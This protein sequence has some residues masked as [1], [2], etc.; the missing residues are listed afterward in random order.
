[1]HNPFFLMGGRVA[2]PIL[3][4]ILV[5]DDEPALLD[6]YST[7]LRMSGF[8][9]AVAHNGAEGIDC[10]RKDCP[11]IM[12]LDVVMPVKD[13]FETLKELKA[14]PSTAG[15][16]VILLTNLGQ[17]HEIKEGM[18]LGAACFLTK[19]NLT[20]QRVVEEVRQVL[21]RNG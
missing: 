17:D 9:V 6:I 7:K 12:L 8:D 19:A 3:V 5:V 18:D 11:R 20:P 21:A 1:M 10:A 4:K 15:I 2:K 16:P 13:G 14:D